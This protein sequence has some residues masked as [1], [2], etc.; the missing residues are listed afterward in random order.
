MVSTKD[1]I[2]CNAK[3]K[4]L[5]ELFINLDENYRDCFILYVTMVTGPP[6]LEGPPG[7]PGPPGFNGLDGVPG[8]PGK[9]EHEQKRIK[10][11]NTPAPGS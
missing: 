3:N 1:L 8:I 5:F 7:P 10:D 2:D 4:Q 6:G 11:I 9:I